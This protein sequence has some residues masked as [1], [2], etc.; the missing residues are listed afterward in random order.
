MGL[1]NAV[2]GVQFQ[3]PAIFVMLDLKPLGGFDTGRV[4]DAWIRTGGESVI[5]FT[6]NGGDNRK[7]YSDTGLEAGK[8]CPCTGCVM[9]YRVPQHPQ[10]VRDWDDD[11]DSTYAYIEFTVPEEYREV[12]K[13]NAPEEEMPPFEVRWKEAVKGMDLKLR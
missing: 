6:R 5:V 12:A 2:L 8:E 10:Y 1:Y 11:F 3:A 7:H 13:A 4:R 9:T